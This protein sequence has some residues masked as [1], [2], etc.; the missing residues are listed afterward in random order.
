MTVRNLSAL[1]TAVIALATLWAIERIMLSRNVTEL[2][3]ADTNHTP[4]RRS[5]LTRTGRRG[6]GCARLRRNP[7]G[8]TTLLGPTH[9]N[10]RE[11]NGPGGIIY[12]P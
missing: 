8:G 12:R 9:A 7:R 5:R 3:P 10:V 4:G 1:L 2:A 6:G 11:Q